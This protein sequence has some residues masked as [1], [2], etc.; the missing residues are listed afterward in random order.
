MHDT[1]ESTKC[2]P[3]LTSHDVSSFI[4]KREHT[5]SDPKMGALQIYLSLPRMETNRQEKEGA[6]WV[7]TDGLSWAQVDRHIRRSLM[8]RQVV[9]RVLLARQAGRKTGKMAG[10]RRSNCSRD[11]EQPESRKARSQT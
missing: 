7:M 6:E 5:L 3:I 9:P 8:G 2:L 4:L 10:M 11:R 1:T